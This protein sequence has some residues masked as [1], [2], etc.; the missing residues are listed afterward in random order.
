[1]AGTL[2]ENMPENGLFTLALGGNN[3][4]GQI[5][6]N[7]R[8]YVDSARNQRGNLN[9]SA[10]MIDM[11]CM[12]D[13]SS[14]EITEYIPDADVVLERPSHPA[15]RQ[16]F[17][18]EA[19][20]LTHAH[21]DHT[22]AIAHYLNR[23]FKFPTVYGTKLTLETVKHQLMSQNL[24]PYLID[25]FMR[26]SVA[27]KDGDHLNLGRFKIEALANSHSFADTLSFKI[28]TPNGRLLHTGDLNTDQS[29]VM[30]G[31]KTN[32]DRF[33]QLAQED[34]DALFIDSTRAPQENEKDISEQEVYEKLKQLATQ[35]F[36]HKKLVICCMGNMHH[37][38][39]SIARVAKETGR[40]ITLTG[41]AHLQTYSAMKASGYNLE[42]KYGLKFNKKE[43]SPEKTI[44]IISGTQ[45]ET[46]AVLAKGLL[47]V[48]PTFSINPKTDVL[49]MMSSV[50]PGNEANIA[51][52]LS[53]APKDL[54]VLT[55]ADIPQ[56]HAGGHSKALGLEKYQTSCKAKCVIPMHGN[57]E[58]IKAQCDIAERNG[59]KSFAQLRNDGLLQITSDGI[60]RINQRVDSWVAAIKT[61]A[62]EISSTEYRKNFSIHGMPLPEQNG[63][64]VNATLLDKAVERTRAKEKER[65]AR[66]QKMLLDQQ[67][68]LRAA[69]GRKF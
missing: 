55:T 48:H 69:H 62:F 46:E 17:P 2:L 6:G 13:L 43:T 21:L 49:L 39:N 33:E 47:G 36:E 38:L 4:N 18:L 31:E 40:D 28:E 11:G 9:Q 66:A 16:E 34:L 26:G 37:R 1:M 51:S 8:L 5:G 60:T 52:V 29:D 65:S 24:D 57:P 67:R 45:G 41:Q 23:G 14:N 27:I 15:H 32:F 59:F 53:L 12:F 61:E 22:G 3:D 63:Y 50:I 25:E 42:K 64:D 56:L 44:E 35:N 68:R 54:K 10:I 20:L 58:M 7:C 30:V 19:L